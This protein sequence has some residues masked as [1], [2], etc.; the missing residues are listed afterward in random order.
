MKADAALE[1]ADS[2]VELNPEPPVNLYLALVVHPG[3]PE[4]D[5]PLGLHDPLVDLGL[6]ELRMFLRRGLQ[7]FHDLLNGL[8]KF[9]LIGIHPLDPL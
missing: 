1:G 6:H 2:V 3:N 7:G 8:M 5:G 9:R 4:Q